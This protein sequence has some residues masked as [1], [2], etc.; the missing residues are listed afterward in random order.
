M[1]LDGA[2][3]VTTGSLGSQIDFNYV[4]NVESSEMFGWSNINTVLYRVSNQ[5]VMLPLYWN[6]G[7]LEG[8]SQNSRFFNVE[9]QLVRIQAG[10][11]QLHQ[12]CQ[13][14]SIQCFKK[15]QMAEGKLGFWEGL[16]ASTW[17]FPLYHTKLVLTQWD[18]GETTRCQD[19]INTMTCENKWHKH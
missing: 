3:V 8:K 1:C 10:K 15:C 18:D 16:S 17:Q 2:L 12:V 14:E 7:E 4:G 13:T 9:S 5:T 6:K 19:K 11:Q